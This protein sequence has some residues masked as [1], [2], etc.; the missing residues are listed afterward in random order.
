MALKLGDDLH[1]AQLRRAGDR[2]A[3]KG[4]GEQIDGAEPLAQL[5][6]DGRDKMMH[7]RIGFE[8]AQLRRLDRAGDAHAREIIAQKV[9]D[10]DVLGAILAAFAERLGLQHV[11]QRV[12]EARP[13]AL[14]RPRLDAPALDAQEALGRGGGDDEIRMI[15]ESRERRR[16]DAAQPAVKPEMIEVRRRRRLKAL[17]QIGLEDV[18]REN[19][20]DHRRDRPLIARPRKIAGP[21]FDRDRPGG[22]GLGR[23]FELRLEP[24]AALDRPPRARRRLH[25]GQ[26]RREDEAAPLEKV[27]SDDDVVKPERKIG[28]GEIVAGGLRQTLEAAAKLIGKK[29]RRAALKWRQAG[30]IRRSIFG[31]DRFQPLDPSRIPLPALN[32]GEGLGGDETIAAEPVIGH[33]A[34]EKGQERQT[35]KREGRLDGFAKI[36]FDDMHGKFR[37]PR[38][39]RRARAAPGRRVL[40]DAKWR[41][42]AAAASPAAIPLKILVKIRGIF[43]TKSSRRAQETPRPRPYLPSFDF[44]AGFGVSVGFGAGAAPSLGAGAGAFAG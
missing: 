16:I 30:R 3:G 36:D 44:S 29:P 12:V 22:R 24:F 38:P 13:R 33:R 31:E 35:L 5:P 17:R 43:P 11:D 41:S 9:H 26:A 42:S 7:A 14:D 8:L 1:R 15:E 32:V 2:T 34:V 37:E 27:E 25:F 23:L 28:K 4:G 20:F 6:D 10:H 21:A 40:L 19:A 39:P 18:A